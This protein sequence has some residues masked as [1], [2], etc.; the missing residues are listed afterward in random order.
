[1][2]NNKFLLNLLFALALALLS[3]PIFGAEAAPVLSPIIGVG[4]FIT[5]QYIPL[6][7]GVLGLNNTNN[8][9][10]REA[11]LNA[12]R[13]F[14]KAFRNKFPEGPGGD[15]MCQDYVD[16]LKLSQNEVR[17]EVA[18][19]TAASSFIFGVNPQQQ[20]TGNTQF[21]T[22]NR[23][24]QQDTLCVNEYGIFVAQTT[25]ANDAAYELETYGNFVT[26]PA[27][28]AAQLN[29]VFYSNGGFQMKCNND[30]IIP[31]R[32][33]YNHKYRGQTQQTAA[34]GAASPGDQLRG[35]EDGFVTQEPNVLLIGS[36]NYVPEIVLKSNLTGTFTNVRA[37]LV[38]RGIL[39]QNSTVVS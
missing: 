25:G 33:L 12:K 36:K 39:A 38:F 11:Y 8:M 2:K 35:A 7:S 28:D 21:L 20:N 19:T 15:K 18:L 14:F 1:M 17:C 24:N 5:L 22:E 34:L 3:A 31:Y 6:P 29:T 13:V 26:F 23:L 10:A 9:S 30:V 37:I 4:C 16:S 32:G 27:A